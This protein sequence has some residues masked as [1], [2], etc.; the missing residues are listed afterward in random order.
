MRDSKR[1]GLRRREIQ[2]LEYIDVKTYAD[3]TREADSCKARV[4]GR[5]QAHHQCTSA[6]SMQSKRD[7]ALAIARAAGQSISLRVSTAEAYFDRPR[8]GDSELKLTSKSLRMFATEA[9]EEPSRSPKLKMKGATSD[10]HNPHTKRS[11]PDFT[12]FHINYLLNAK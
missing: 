8:R 5:A 12:K 2:R 1:Q 10:T 7:W 6:K 4:Y 9:T 3:I 11:A